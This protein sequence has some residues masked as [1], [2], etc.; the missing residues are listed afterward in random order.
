MRKISKLIL[1]LFTFL[2][3]MSMTIGVFATDESSTPTDSTAGVAEAVNP[4]EPLPNDADPEPIAETEIA[5]PEESY[6]V[7]QYTSGGNITVYN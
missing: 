7:K 5:P 4:T 1:V 2:L 6:T 3:V